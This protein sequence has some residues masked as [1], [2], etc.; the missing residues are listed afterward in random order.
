MTVWHER[1]I[2][3]CQAYDPELPEGYIKLSGLGNR[4]TYIGP[5]AVAM[6]EYFF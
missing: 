5:L 3:C 1:F 2:Q 6:D 4:I